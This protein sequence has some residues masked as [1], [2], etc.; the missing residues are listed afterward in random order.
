[1]NRPGDGG[2][3]LLD[4]GTHN[5]FYAGQGTC[6]RGWKVIVW[7]SCGEATV[8]YVGERDSD[9]PGREPDPLDDLR[10]SASRSRTALRRYLVH[11]GLGHMITLTFRHPP[12][13]LQALTEK[14]R[15]FVRRLER[16]GISGA[17]AWVPEHGSEH[18]RLHVHFACEWWGRLGAVE[19][20]ERCATSSLAKVRD[21]VPAAGSLCVG[22]IWGHGFV[23]RPSE[24]VGDP[25]GLA[26][27]VSKYAAKDFGLD[28]GDRKGRNRYRIARGYQPEPVVRP[29]V[30]LS[31]ADSL[32]RRLT[33][34]SL[35]D[36][37]ALHSV[38][39]DWKGP[40]TWVATF[41]PGRS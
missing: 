20:C 8:A 6:Q 19:V 17:Y 15:L 41:G 2:V 14:M 40:A 10:R 9:A 4:K 39:E 1:M 5:G 25:R 11:N 34:V 18:G 31:H 13:S 33:G 38:V 24:A 30:S 27:Y 16:A 23:G 28:G 32:L 12:G 29:A 35:R 21:D 7:P 37:T 26:V 3:P 36:A 22:C